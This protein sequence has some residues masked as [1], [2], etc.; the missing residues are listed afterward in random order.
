M[1]MSFENFAEPRTRDS[2]KEAVGVRIRLAV[3]ALD[4]GVSIEVKDWW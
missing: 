3:S 1:V 4:G 2:R